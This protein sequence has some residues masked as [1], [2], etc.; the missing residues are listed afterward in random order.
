MRT[1]PALRTLAA[2]LLTGGTLA[3]AAAGTYGGGSP[4]GHTTAVA[5][6]RSDPGH[7]RLPRRPQRASRAHHA[8]PR[9]RQALAGQPG[10]RGRAWSMG[11]ASTATRTGT[12]SRRPGLGERRLRR[13]RRR[14]VPTCA[15]PCPRW[16][17]GALDATGTTRTRNDSVERVELPEVQLLRL[18]EL[19]GL[20][21]LVGLSGSG[22]GR[23]VARPG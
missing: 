18:V 16:K 7:H 5:I 19:Q 13:H 6:W 20:R 10:P 9:R 2:A 21:V 17:D 11:R 22:P 12:G 23:S 14:S 15:D 8:L 3:V 4:V 1:T